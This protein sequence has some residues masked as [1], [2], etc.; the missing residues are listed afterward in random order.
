MHFASPKTNSFYFK[1]MQQLISSQ[2]KKN[3]IIKNWTIFFLLEQ[4]TTCKTCIAFNTK[5]KE[6]D[7]SGFF[8]HILMS[9]ILICCCELF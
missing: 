9:Q 1:K 8:L 3:I 7:S 5:L 2:V 6:N 4:K